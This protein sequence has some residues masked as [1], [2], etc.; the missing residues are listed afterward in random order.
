M[1]FTPTIKQSL[2]LASNDDICMM[3]GGAGSGKSYIMLW[4]AL[5]LNDA[6]FGARYQLPYY[7][8]LIFRKQYRQLSEL[9]DK[10][11]TIYPMVDPGAIFTSTNSTWTFSSGA[12]IRLSY[13]E[14]YSQVESLQGISY[15]Y[16]GIDEIGTYEDDRIFK[17]ALS[18]LRSPEGLKPYCRLTSNPSRYAWLRDYFRISEHGE[19]TNFKLEY[20]LAD[21]TKAYKSIRYIQAMLKDNPHLGK[22]YEAQLMMLPDDERKALLEGNWLAYNTVEGQVYEHELKKLTIENRVCHVAH[23]PSVP[24][25]TVWDIGISDYCVILF[26]QIVGKEIRIIDMIKDNNKSIKEHY[27]PNILQWKD[28]KGYRYEAHYLPHDSAQRDKFTGITILEQCRKYL[29]DVKML[30]NIRLADGLQSTKAMFP[31]LFINK[32]LSLYSDLVNYRREWDDKL[33]IYK[34]TP[35]HDKYSHTADAL[36]YISYIKP[37]M[38]VDTKDFLANTFYNQTSPFA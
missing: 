1:E 35:L 19:S 7:R 20:V 36:R 11:K 14:T 12:Q 38:I 15:A 8:A 26:V 37:K 25:I 4:D 31:N 17:Y 2:F 34:D 32:A 10:S 16:I 29:N 9:I 23:D 24:V 27:I 18:R 28:S 13:F 6:K 3:A 33:S 22:D 21:G 5:G 30:P